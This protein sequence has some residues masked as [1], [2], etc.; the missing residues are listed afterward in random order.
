M[1]A[2]WTEQRLRGASRGD[3]FGLL[4]VAIAG[5]ADAI[6]EL[7]A[8]LLLD[9]ARSLVRRKVKIRMLAEADPIADRV[10]ARAH[11]A[12]GR[13]TLPTDRGADVAD[14][15]HTERALDPFGG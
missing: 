7:P 14:V 9:D 3:G 1:L 8:R 12:G 11:L 13:T 6:L 2:R 5:A 15:V 10:R 4:L